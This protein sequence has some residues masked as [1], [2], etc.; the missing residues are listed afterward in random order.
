MQPRTV[1]RSVGWATV[2]AGT[3]VVL[4]FATLL[5]TAR[6]LGP[7]DFG[8]AATTLA[9]IQLLNVLVEPLFGEVL[10]QRSDLSREHVD[11]AFWG[12]L[13]MACVVIAACWIAAR[14]MAA[15]YGLPELAAILRV[16]SLGLLFAAYNGVQSAVLRRSFGF[17]ELAMRSLGARLAGAS[18][19]IG[20]ALKGAGPWSLIAQ[21]LL[22]NTLGAVALWYWSPHRLGGAPRRA[23]LAEL[24]RFVV[25]WLG[26][27]LV[28]VWQP[29]IF[30]L[31][32]GYLIGVREFAFLS[33]AFRVVET[34]REVIGHVASNVGLPYFARAQ[35]D[36]PL[37]ADRFIAATSIVCMIAMPAFAGLAVCADSAVSVVLGKAWLPAVP[38]VH[39]LAA[40]VT[41]LW[42]GI[43]SFAICTALAR[44]SMNLPRAACELAAMATV[45]CLLADRGPVF[46]AA[47]WA[48]RHLVSM[49]LGLR[50]CSRLLR[51]DVG[52]IVG[53]VAGPTLTACAMAAILSGVAQVLPASAPPLARLAVL[54]PTGVAL[55]AA[56]GAW[57]YPH[58]RRSGTD[59]LRHAWSAVAARPTG[60]GD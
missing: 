55:I 36:P 59:R 4:S 28:V 21:Y 2:E 47:A 49:L 39:V 35:G 56:I 24:L 50:M 5:F 37:L 26:S 58:L 6:L 22:N 8:V 19:G 12:A 57:T 48:V 34:L 20:L 30:L 38:M 45:L 42:A 14:P 16:A 3:L 10:V 1:L 27:Y 52:R 31:A 15:A 23:A 43:F 13:V 17:R 53:A 9:V 44:P 32:A 7:R 41:V 46:V 60:A 25:P 54:M 18:V 33:V 40:G 11:T 51:L 29:R